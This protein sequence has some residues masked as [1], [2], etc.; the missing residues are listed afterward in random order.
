MEH[1]PAEAQVVDM[2][3]QVGMN[4]L[5]S[6]ISNS[7]ITIPSI[8]QELSRSQIHTPLQRRAFCTS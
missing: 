4:V 3:E 7:V 5:L 1:T 6:K 2:W 8:S